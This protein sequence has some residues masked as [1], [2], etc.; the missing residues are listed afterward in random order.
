MEA[1]LFNILTVSLFVLFNVQKSIA[2]SD[3]NYYK[4]EEKK[5]YYINWVKEI[6][7]SLQQSITGQCNIQFNSSSSI[8]TADSNTISVSYSFPSMKEVYEYNNRPTMLSKGNKE[9]PTLLKQPMIAAWATEKEERWMIP[10]DHP[11]K[12]MYV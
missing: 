6:K 12:G 2:R 8:E 10:S 7:E 11:G 4:K 5:S 3:Y 1:I 9:L